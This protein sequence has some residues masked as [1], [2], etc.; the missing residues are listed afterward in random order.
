MAQ[1]GISQ[2][3]GFV[4]LGIMGGRMVRQLL[5]GGVDLT[6]HDL[7][8]A[9]LQAA[10]D[11][12]AK[13]AGTPKELGS[14][15]DVVIAMLPSPQILEAVALGA[16]GL[17]EGMAAGSLLVDMATDGMS[18][19]KRL[20]VPLAEKGIRMI[21]APVGRGPEAAE[22]GDLI[23]LIGGNRKDCDDAR[24]LM[25]LLGSEIHY[26][27]P[28]GAGQA[29]KLV[30]NL[31][32]SATMSVVAEGYALAKRAGAD[33]DVMT[34][35]LPGSAA[36][37]WQL[38]NGLIGKALAGDFSPR[39]KV[40]LA[41]KDVALAVEMADELGSPVETGRA[42]LGWFDTAMDAGHGDLDRAA[43]VLTE[44]PDLQGG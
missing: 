18:V 30:N 36:D 11:V 16:D 19:V 35:L 1:D 10:V 44:D 12:G 2:R 31:V 13:V 41:R 25:G 20:A 5:Q 3:V 27:G 34:K 8:A 42:A 15:C 21:D 23:I 6:V 7:D 39:F 29:I 24:G 14:T 9:A 28:L 17:I 33:I 22:T 32:S 26:C 40:S 37:S 43:I 38:R 4:G